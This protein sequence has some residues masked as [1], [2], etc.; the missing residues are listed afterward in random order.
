[1]YSAVIL[2]LEEAKKM[3]TEEIDFFLD[4]ELVVKQLNGEYKVKNEDLGKLFVKIYNLRQ[5][6]KKTTFHH[7]MRE[8][9]KLADRLV[10]EAID[11]R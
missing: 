2:A 7:V 10:N 11:G 1:E 8:K 9:N 6:F 3:E 4:S 5:Q